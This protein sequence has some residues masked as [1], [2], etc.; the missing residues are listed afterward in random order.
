MLKQRKSPAWP[1]DLGP[2]SPVERARTIAR[3]ARALA[4]QWAPASEVAKL[5]RFA[6]KWGE[7]DW[8]I[9]APATYVDGD[10]MTRT[11]VAEMAGVDTPAVVMWGKRGIRRGGKTEHLRTRDRDDL[12]EYRDVVDF[13]RRRDSPDI[14]KAPPSPCRS[15]QPVISRVAGTGS[16]PS[17]IRPSM[18]TR[19]AS[20][21]NT[22]GTSL[23]ARHR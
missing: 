7:L 3:I 18:L 17:A 15:T 4:T 11:Q 8:L 2:N 19:T 9:P 16:V 6:D 23:S 20:C 1:A 10:P 12:Y 5:D 22:T 21:G 13:L 14:R